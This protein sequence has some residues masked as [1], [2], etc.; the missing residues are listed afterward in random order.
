MDPLTIN[1]ILF[2]ILGWLF[3]LLS[4]TIISNIRDQREAQVIKTALILEL[5]E[6]MYRLMMNVYT[7]E[8]KYGKLDHEFFIWA[9]SVLVQYK[10]INSSESLLKTIGPILKLTEDEISISLEMIKNEKKKKS[11]LSLKKNSLMLLDTNMG[12]LSKLEPTFMGKLLEIKTRLGFL[13]EII[14]DTR[15]YYK[16]SFQNNISDENYEIANTNLIDHYKFYASRSR[17]IIR[18]IGEVL[19]IK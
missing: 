5:H 2:L 17:D 14:D 9:Q 12:V 8:S 6:L 4:P 18:I 13:N 10:G 3:G 11:A 19:D 16:L 15:Y 7:V 1:Q